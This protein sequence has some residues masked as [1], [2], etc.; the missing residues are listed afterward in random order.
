M[1]LLPSNV[2]AY[3]IRSVTHTSQGYH[4]RRR[5]Q[6]RKRGGEFHCHDDSNMGKG[7]KRAPTSFDSDI[8]NAK[9]ACL[10]AEDG[11][12]EMTVD[13]FRLNISR[14]FIFCNI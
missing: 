12:I 1:N 13:R 5:P 9:K 2:P 8:D 14:S 7:K 3:N 10:V 6:G 11:D 4:T